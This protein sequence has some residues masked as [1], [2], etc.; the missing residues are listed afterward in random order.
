MKTIGIKLSLIVVIA[1]LGLLLLPKLS[2]ADA[3]TMILDPAFGNVEA[4]KDLTVKV[5]V[6]GSNEQIDGVDANIAYDVDF[7]KVKEMKKGSAFSDYPTFKD[8]NGQVQITAIAGKDGQSLSGEI[9]IAELIFEIQDSGST[10]LT[11]AFQ[12]GATSESNVSGHANGKDLLTTVAGGSYTVNAT[13][14]KLRAAQAK[15]AGRSIVPFIIFIIVLILIALG[16][17]YYRKKRKKEEDYFVPEAFPMDE[18]PKSENEQST[19]PSSPP[20]TS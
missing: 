2:T 5:I 7:L 16:I 14:E 12:E 9:V 15:K 20:S 3:A 11:V 19:P 8:I 10:K 17:W 18:V 4:G 13:E 1:L 6:Q